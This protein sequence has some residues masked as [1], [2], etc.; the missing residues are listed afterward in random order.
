M[1]LLNEIKDIYIDPDI[2]L[3][4][5]DMNI[6]IDINDFKI[7]KV[8]MVSNY[9][10]KLYLENDTGDKGWSYITATDESVLGRNILTKLLISQKIIKVPFGVLP[11]L[12]LNFF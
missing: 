12:D 3:G 10:M 2:I 9:K 1:T 5:N 11:K 8:E 7:K 4:N 6:E